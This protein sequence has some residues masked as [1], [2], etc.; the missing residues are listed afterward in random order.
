MPIV[1]R[2]KDFGGKWTTPHEGPRFSKESGISVTR[3]WQLQAAEDGGLYAGVEPAGLFRSEDRGETW[4]SDDALNYDSGREKWEPGGGGLCLHTILPYPGD[5]R[6]MLVGISAAGIFA[7]NDAGSSWRMYDAGIRYYGKQKLFEKEDLATCVHK[8]VRD[9]KDPAIVYQ[10]NHAGMYRR[11][12]GDGA[13]KIIEKGLPVSK[14]SGG[15]FGFPLA[16]HPHD[17]QSAYAIPLVGDYNRV[18]PDGTMAV[19]RTTN[20]GKQWS[21]RTKG[22]PQSGAWFTV[23]REG[24]RTDSNDPAGVYAGTTTGQLY[25]SRDDG[26]S[27]HLMADHLPPIQSVEAG[28]VGPS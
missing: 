23:L 9:A 25:H 11:T 3:I 28:N 16:A 2:T 17:A 24:L 14:S 19:Y 7:T 10:Q 20:G 5:P 1:A 12:R 26:E 6:R 27:W 22:L 18:M 4:A 21:K 13:W 15:T 8:M